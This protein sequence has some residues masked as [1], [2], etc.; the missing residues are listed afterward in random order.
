M[1]ND[2]TLTA[3]A[4]PQPTGLDLLATLWRPG[5][6]VPIW[7]KQPGGRLLPVEAGQRLDEVLATAVTDH[8]GRLGVFHGVNPVTSDGR[9]IRLAALW[10]ALNIRPGAL[11][12]PID[13]WTVAARLSDMLDAT[14]AFVIDTGDAIY[15][16]W[17]IHHYPLR[18]SQ[19]RGRAS[20]VLARWGRLVAQAAR[21][22]D[23]DAERL[24]NVYDL[25]RALPIPA[26]PAAI[27]GQGGRSIT[28]IKVFATLNKYGESELPGDRRL[29]LDPVVSQYGRWHP[30]PC[31]CGAL[32]AIL[33]NIMRGSPLPGM[34][35]HYWAGRHA[36]RLAVARRVGC[37]SERGLDEAEPVLQARL[38]ELRAH[39]SPLRPDE[40]TELLHWA[41]DTVSRWSNERVAEEHHCITG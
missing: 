24:D 40:A 38:Y 32:Q 4:E 12:E 5:E 10:A 29:T 22:H 9:I 1:A 37:I 11:D 13:A 20:A 17:P 36:L 31:H 27:Q 3:T 30:D 15:P 18:T 14:P 6:A 21:D 34:S 8:A 16:Y 26:N 28:A 41:L 7:I 33:A 19:E 2:Q 39:E 25:T 35:R 23:I